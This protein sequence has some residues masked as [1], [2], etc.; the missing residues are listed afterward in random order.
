[1]TLIDAPG[2]PAA[3]ARQSSPTR[4]ASR[5]SAAPDRYSSSVTR[6]DGQPQL[7]LRW[8]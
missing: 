6:D 4:A 1:L 3:I 2:A 7:R 8:R 5:M